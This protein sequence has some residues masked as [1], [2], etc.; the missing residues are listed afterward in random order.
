[1]GSGEGLHGDPRGPVAQ[2]LHRGLVGPLWRELSLTHSL[3][4][5]IDTDEHPDTWLIS[6]AKFLC[7]ALRDLPRRAAHEL[8]QALRV[9]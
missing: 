9:W 6:Y 5:L 1:M 3:T 2:K 4:R 7:E 8:D